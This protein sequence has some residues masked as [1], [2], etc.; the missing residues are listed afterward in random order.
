MKMDLCILSSVLSIMYSCMLHAGNFTNF[1]TGNHNCC[2]L[3]LKLKG[4][5]GF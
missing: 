5:C 3:L 2:G 1:Y 4:F